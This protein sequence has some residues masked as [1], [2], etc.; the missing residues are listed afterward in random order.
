[1]SAQP[2][3]VLPLSVGKPTAAVVVVDPVTAERWLSRNSRNRKVRD[4]VVDQYARDMATGRWQVTGEAIKFASDGSLLDG[5]HRLSAVVKS[6]VTV[7]MFVV[8]GLHPQSQGAMDTGS[9]RTASDVLDIAGEQNTS[10]IAAMTRL[11]LT[12][13]VGRLGSRWQPSHAEITV[14]LAENPEIRDFAAFARGVARRT[15]CPPAVV[16]YTTWI[17]SKIDPAAAREFWIAA[18]EKVGLSPGDPVIALTNRFAES[19]R[20]KVPLSQRALLSV[21]YRAWNSRRAGKPMRL[22]KVNSNADG[23]GLIPIPDPR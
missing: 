4:A 13:Q 9:K 8:R 15:D 2:E 7:Q 16:A 12:V 1:M 3:N 5:Q 18:A 23:G 14:F 10:L 11:A 19:R 20:N 6:G 22:I 17:F 21:I